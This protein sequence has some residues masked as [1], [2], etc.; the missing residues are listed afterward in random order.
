MPS[1]NEYRHESLEQ[2]SLSRVSAGSTALSKG[3]VALVALGGIGIA[4]WILYGGLT[5][6]PVKNDDSD[7]NT[8][9]F[10]P[11]VVTAENLQPVRQAPDIIR[12]EPAPK[13]PSLRYLLPKW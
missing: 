9:R 4:A 7:F 13:A 3:S 11:P 1:P 5:R 12:I 2:D 6:Q 10:S 8:T